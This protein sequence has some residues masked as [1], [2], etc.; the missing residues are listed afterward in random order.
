MFFAA[1]DKVNLLVF[2]ECHHSTGNTT[3]ARIMREHYKSCRNRPR[4]LGLT[5]SISAAKIE[6]DKLPKVAKELEDLF[7]ARIETGSDRMEIHRNSTSVKT[8]Y[9]RCANYEHKIHRNEKAVA[10]IFKVRI[11]I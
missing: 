1:L 10:N 3:Y 11:S 6:A 2:D 5:A 4:I 8:Q 9:S 7:N